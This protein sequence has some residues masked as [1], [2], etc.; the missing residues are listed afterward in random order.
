MEQEILATSPSRHAIA[1]WRQTLSQR[2]EMAIERLTDWLLI[3]WLGTINWGLGLLLGGAVL[4]PI[5]AW[6]GI[7]PLAG[8]MFRAY[9]L[10]CEQVPSHSLFIFGHQLALCARNGSLYLALWLGTM[11]FRPLRQYL[12]PLDWR[13]LLLFLLPMAIDGTT[14]LM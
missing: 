12:K 2:F 8:M 14:Q 3:H 13:I 6:L 4:T 10:I 7:E 1:P 5:L 11:F 9:H